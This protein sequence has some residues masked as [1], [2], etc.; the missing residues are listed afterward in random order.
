MNYLKKTQEILEDQ[1]GT[2]AE[3]ITPETRLVED[4][5]CDSLDAVE[6]M[7]AFEDEFGIE[8]NEEEAE[9]CRTVADILALLERLKPSNT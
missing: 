9:K 8:V 2:R 6:L 7:M 3:D 1:F 5:A 4:L